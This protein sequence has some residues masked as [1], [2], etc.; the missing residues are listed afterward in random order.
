LTYFITWNLSKPHPTC[1][2]YFSSYDIYASKLP[3]E[4]DGLDSLIFTL[5]FLFLPS[6]PIPP[7]YIS[8]INSHPDIYLPCKEEAAAACATSRHHRVF[9]T[10]LSL[11]PNNLTFHVDARSFF[12][13]FIFCSSAFFFM[14]FYFWMKITAD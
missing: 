12:F 13:F 1:Q 7:V 6:S 9:E 3:K 5:S 8:V 14:V 10:V 2:L 4:N 11:L